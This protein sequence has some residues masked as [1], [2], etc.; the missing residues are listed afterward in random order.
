MP[1][2][3]LKEGETKALWMNNLFNSEKKRFILLSLIL[4][5]AT[6]FLFQP[7][8]Q[9]KFLN[10]D[11]DNYITENARLQSG[12]NWNT[13]R[14]AFTTTTLANWHPLTWLSYMLDYQLFRLNP[15]GYHLTNLLLH[16]LNVVLLF[17]VLYCG[18]G[19]LWRSFSVAALFAFHPLNVQ[20]VAW[21]AERKNVLSTL[22]WLLAIAAYGW[23][24]L[25]PGLR[26]YFVALIPF[27]LGLM[28]KPMIV[29]LPFVLLLLDY[30]PL[31][32]MNF[33]Q[34]RDV[35]T[36]TKDII[37]LIFEKTPWILL[38][39]ASAIVTIVAQK[40]G[41]AVKSVTA[42]PF[43]VRLE[44]ALLAYNGY[45]QKMLW[46][47]HLAV[48]YPHP[49]NS[50]A[51]WK[52]AL[53]AAFL[54]FISWLVVRFR[55]KRY[56]LF[57]W[58]FYLGTLVPVIGLVQIGNQAMADRYAYIPAMG[59][60][61]MMVWSISEWV[62]A[63]QVL[64]YLLSAAFV[65]VLLALS[66]NSR[67]QLGYWRDSQTLFSHALEV[68]SN[69]ATAQVCLGSALAE[70]GRLEEA[71]DHFHA[72]L[73]IKPN[74][75]MAHFN[76][77]AYRLYQGDRAGAL[78]E[79]QLALHYTSSNIVAANAHVQMAVIYSQMGRM[80]E[81]KAHY[82]EAIQLD[83]MQYKAYLNL[84]VHL[85]LEGDLDGAISS[86]SHSLEIIPTSSAY[87]YLGE[88]LEREN[89]PAEALTAYHEALKI[90]SEPAEIQ[91]HIDAI[92]KKQKALPL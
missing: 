58:F 20:S 8:G 46:P 70:A 10:Y 61:V 90:S 35:T 37:A 4:I 54:I 82:R 52:V 55:G 29:T 38:S 62:C 60:F 32:R 91:N 16:E 53:A 71:A 85:Y 22:F 87:F 78:Q 89:R 47:S 41:G 27:A 3:Q 92:L 63:R 86:L 59:L 2:F 11:D 77:G 39:L 42:Y 64:Q 25:K 17:F 45:V 30:W 69:N 65:V 50:S 48:F 23:Y 73:R 31:Q 40:S 34:N 88:A 44:N 15:G 67:I 81:S 74:D 68:T 57:G 79:F 56:L 66:W 13:F 33:D 80:E 72:A 75:E 43:T 84:G 1:L 19:F 51:V 9:Y 49:G 5:A 26:R 36:Q 76:L 18:T 83:D 14:W 12:L 28:A 6:T 7:L 24:V 21:V